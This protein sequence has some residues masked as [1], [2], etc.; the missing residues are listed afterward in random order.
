MNRTLAVSLIAG[1]LVLAAGAVVWALRP[2]PVIDA[3]PLPTFDYADAASW[4]VKPDP[5]P[6]AVW[7]G[8]WDVD[9]VLISRAEALEAGDGEDL[10][11][12]RGKSAEALGKQ[13]G[14]LGKIGPTYAPYLRNANFEADV[15]AALNHY[16][17]ED[18][19]G[20]A[21]FVAT[22]SPLPAD[23]IMVLRETP[24]F[25][26]RFGGVLFF[27]E[28]AETSGFAS[29]VDATTVCSKRYKAEQTCTERV[30]LRRSGGSYD[31]TG[32]GRLVNGFVTWLNA[33]TSKLAEPLGELEE[34]EIIDI[35]RPGE[36]E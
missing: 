22:D 16:R 25:R 3:S 19:R 32:G 13:A 1:L 9:V 15:A 20:R 10:E 31:L 33:N 23:F 12:Q 30:E 11:K 6:P 5:M 24:L 7:E 27:G 26:D 36:T 28:D 2:Q 14:A 21:F 17:L 18:N 34:V 8:D 4:A 29:D 35:R